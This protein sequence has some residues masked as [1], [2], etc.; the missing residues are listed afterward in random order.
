MYRLN[1]Y[2]TSSKQNEYIR[3]F[4]LKKICEQKKIRFTFLHS[5]LIRIEKKKKKFYIK[6]NV[7]DE[8]F[9]VFSNKEKMKHFQNFTELKTWI[10]D[11]F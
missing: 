3:F 6:Y 8:E 10:H 1:L 11:Y 9:Y 7:L 5:F 4:I 2:Q